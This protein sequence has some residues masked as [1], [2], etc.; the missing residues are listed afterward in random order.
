MKKTLIGIVLSLLMIP[1]AFAEDNLD[2][3][4]ELIN[5][6]LLNNKATSSRGF[7][8]DISFILDSSYVYRDLTNESFSSLKIPFFTKDVG[9]FSKNGFNINYGELAL[10]STVDPY[11]DLSAVLPFTLGGVEV[12]EVFITSRALPFGFQL[13]MGKFRSNWGR[14]N[15]QHEH[16][17]DF[18]DAPLLYTLFFGAEQLNETGLQ[19]NWIA[20]LDTY[21]LVGTELLQGTNQVSFGT[22][23]FT[24]GKASISENNLPNLAVGYL[25]TSFDIDDLTLLGGLSIAYGGT[26]KNEITE[27]L[28]NSFAF[29]GNTKIYGTDLTLKYFINSYSY[30]ALQS[31]F[32]YKNA[33][34]TKFYSDSP[35]NTF[36]QNQSGLYSQLVYKFNETWKTGLRYDLM[37][38]N[39]IFEKN[40]KTETQSNLA[41]YSAMIECTPTEFSR[42]RLQYNHDRTK[43]GD[44]LQPV[45]EIFLQLN[46]AIGA[47]G[48]HSF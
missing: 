25:K 9:D 45:N 7:L 28:K 40:L 15:I 36:N 44:T 43:F 38:Q 1:N 12:E 32:M 4:A 13:K 17:W 47:H 14:L 16:A 39:E 10:N 3:D 48:A 2:S 8:P 22:D 46:M 35:S 37:L 29:D 21:F 41:K 19:L 23:G 33:N 18:V 42:I 27:D 34:L 26:K 11:F 24:L 6:N 5:N 30:L 20:P 31:E